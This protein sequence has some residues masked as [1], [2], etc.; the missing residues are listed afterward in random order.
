[1]RFE[2]IKEV[3]H[4]KPTGAEFH[5]TTDS[6]IG[7]L[8]KTIDGFEDKKRRTARNVGIVSVLSMILLMVLWQIFPLFYLTS[9]IGFL[10]M[11][12]SIIMMTIIARSNLINFK[13]YYLKPHDFILYILQ[14]LRF[15]RCMPI[16]AAPLYGIMLFTGVTLISQ[17]TL[18]NTLFEKKIIYYSLL[19]LYGII[20]TIWSIRRENRKFTKQYHSLMSELESLLKK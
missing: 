20:M 4:Q 12:V 5:V 18:K 2:D 13:K 19:Y 1:M 6:S 7:Q 10:L 14:K 8:I 9:K 11:I 15:R 3:W 16:I 17:E